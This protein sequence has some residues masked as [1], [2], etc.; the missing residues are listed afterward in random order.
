M[1]PLPFFFSKFKTTFQVKT[2][3]KY[4]ACYLA[5]SYTGINYPMNK[6]K[7]KTNEVVCWNKHKNVEIKIIKLQFPSP[8]GV[9]DQCQKWSCS[10]SPGVEPRPAEQEANTIPKGHG[11]AAHKVVR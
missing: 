8:D 9:Y 1:I 6:V 4:Y 10:T 5:L 3:K 7:L 2:F 11:I